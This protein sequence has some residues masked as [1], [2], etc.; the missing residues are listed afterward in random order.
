MRPNLPFAR[1]PIVAVAEE[2]IGRFQPDVIVAG[3][4]E[5][6]HVDHRTNN[7]LVVKAMQELLREGGINPG[8][9]FLVDKS[10]GE[11]SWIH[12]PYRYQN[13]DLFVPGEVARR[14]QEALWFYQTQDGNH[15]QGDLV[16]S[17][18]LKR[19]EADPHQ[20]LLY[21]KDHAGWNERDLAA[22]AGSR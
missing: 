3:H 5:E 21:W 18:K 1:D 15:Q 4:P 17:D 16:T 13:F 11:T 9:R 7:W 2:F 22:S 10:Y 19:N 20:W 12:S 14:G 8:T 6:R